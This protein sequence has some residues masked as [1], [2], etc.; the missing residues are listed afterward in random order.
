MKSTGLT[1]VFS[2]VLKIF[3]VA[4]LVVGFG[5]IIFGCLLQSPPKNFTPV[6]AFGSNKLTAP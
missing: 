4:S 1:A 3:A 2:L 6:Y 5:F